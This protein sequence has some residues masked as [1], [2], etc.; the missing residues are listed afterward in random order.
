[1]N[2]SGR[3]ERYLM[4]F[5][6]L[7]LTLHWPGNGAVAGTPSNAVLIAAMPPGTESVIVQRVSMLMQEDSV[8]RE[9][10][11]LAPR[12]TN[13]KIK[14]VVRN[15]TNQATLVAYALG[16]SD[17]QMPPTAGMTGNFDERAIY[18]VEQSVADLRE[19]L[20]AG[21]DVEDLDERFDVGGVRVYQGTIRVLTDII[22]IHNDKIVDRLVLCQPSNDG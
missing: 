8:F 10:Y 2:G 12:T 14:A 3:S 1:M 16:G 5:G 17:F 20:E 19:Q 18:V 13:M 21:R 11:D 22:K 6:I 9:G 15:A 4:V 7:G